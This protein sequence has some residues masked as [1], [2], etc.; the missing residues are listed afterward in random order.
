MKS[1]IWFA[2]DRDIAIQS[3]ALSISRIPQCKVSKKE[4]ETLTE[5]A[6]TAILQQPP[7]TKIGLRDRV[8]M[9]LLYDS[10]IRLE[11]LLC[12][13]LKDISIKTDNPYI[14]ISGK[15]NKERIIAIT[16]KTSEHLNQYLTVYHKNDLNMNQYLLLKLKESQTEC[17]LEMWNVLLS[18]MQKVQERNVFKYQ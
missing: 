6:I 3:V 13:T 10:A 5:E 18:S 7:S 2:S 17:L 15:G 16:I 9:I 8:I 11:E 4:K 1:Y 14:R 12:L